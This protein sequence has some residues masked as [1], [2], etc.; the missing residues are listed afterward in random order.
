M[1]LISLNLKFYY[2][3]LKYYVVG[4]ERNFKYLNMYVFCQNIKICS[5]FRRHVAIE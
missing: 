5:V 3:V 2:K 1:C 4:Y